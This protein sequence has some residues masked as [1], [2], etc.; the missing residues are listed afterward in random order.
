MNAATISVLDFVESDDKT[1]LD[2]NLSVLTG[3]ETPQSGQHPE[4][5]G[6]LEHSDENF[7]SIQ[8]FVYDENH[9]PHY[10]VSLL[11]KIK[12][13]R[14]RDIWE[15]NCDVDDLKEEIREIWLNRVAPHIPGILSDPKVAPDKIPEEGAAESLS[16]LPILF[17]EF[18][19][20][21]TLHEA[22][23]GDNPAQSIEKTIGAYQEEL[24]RPGIFRCIGIGL[25]GTTS[26][27]SRGGFKMEGLVAT[28]EF[29]PVNLDFP[30][31]LTYSEYIFIEF[32]RQQ[33]A[34]YEEDTGALVN[35]RPLK[36]RTRELLY[37]RSWYFK[38]EQVLGQYD[39]D[40]S[41]LKRELDVDQEMQKVKSQLENSYSMEF[42]MQDY[43]TS[44]EQ[45]H[46]RDRDMLA[47]LNQ[48]FESFVSLHNLSPESMFAQE[49]RKVFHQKL[50]DNIENSMNRTNQICSLLPA[51]SE[52]IN[53]RLDKYL[54]LRTSSA[55]LKLQRAIYVLTLFLLILAVS[56]WLS[57]VVQTG[58][59]TIQ[60]L[61][62]RVGGI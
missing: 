34:E 60:W 27:I 45:R 33:S 57:S 4:K 6:E 46:L 61:I 36:R 20:D 1:E 17:C 44:V 55:T 12:Q 14:L 9:G 18:N 5:W 22:I 39:N 15:E 50:A 37:L 13:S 3:K 21:R 48:W 29:S 47:N 62:G 30:N 58:I 26:L 53:N 35:L 41:E 28:P 59:R 38:A 24:A 8:L 16:G 54:R 10:T 7:D 52:A 56:D 11:G 40:L 23:A 19:L 42:E 25:R 43:C 49:D 32:S 51:E 2:N 31:A